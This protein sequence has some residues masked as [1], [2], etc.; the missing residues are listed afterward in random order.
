[1]GTISHY[2]SLREQNELGFDSRSYTGISNFAFLPGC[3]FMFIGSGWN[4]YY[5]ARVS[6][7]RK[8]LVRQG[9]TR[10]GEKLRI[11]N[12]LLVPGDP[13]TVMYCPSL[14]CCWRCGQVS[15]A[16]TIQLFEYT[17]LTERGLMMCPCSCTIWHLDEWEK[18]WSVSSREW[19]PTFLKSLCTNSRTDF[20]CLHAII[21]SVNL[22]HT[23]TGNQNW[24]LY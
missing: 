15:Y 12:E 19:Y 24:K 17:D 1:M 5:S 13:G 21:T 2:Y 6:L 22:Y 16:A 10:A 11:W 14:E 9:T 7:V 3:L 8:C 4:K 18:L 20:F 23:I